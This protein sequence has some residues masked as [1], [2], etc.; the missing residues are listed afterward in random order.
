MACVGP[1]GCGVSFNLQGEKIKGKWKEKGK[2]S[3]LSPL[4]R[5]TSKWPWFPATVALVYSLI[6]LLAYVEEDLSLNIPLD[7]YKYVTHTCSWTVIIAWDKEKQATL[8]TVTPTGQWVS[9]GWGGEWRQR[10]HEELVSWL[11]SWSLPVSGMADVDMLQAFLCPE[12][13]DL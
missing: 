4:I 3:T 2:C 9:R 13:T 10:L 1:L 6:Y 12:S 8:G 5:S 7:V 11:L